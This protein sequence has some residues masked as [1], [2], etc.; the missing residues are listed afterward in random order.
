MT[1]SLRRNYSLSIQS[2][3]WDLVIEVSNELNS[4]ESG[5]TT[6][7]MKLKITTVIGYVLPLIGSLPPMVAWGG[8][9]T[10]PFVVYLVMMVF[11]LAEAPPLPDI[12]NLT[13]FI[14]IIIQISA[15]IFL[16]WSVVYLRKEN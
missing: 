4:A 1:G 3:R 12:I 10:V 9:M 16:I 14:V 5:T 7:R 15:L 13:T 2:S 6:E 8:L 11:N